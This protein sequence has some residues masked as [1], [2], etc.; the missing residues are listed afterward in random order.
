MISGDLEVDGSVAFDGF[1][2][3]GGNAT[4][5]GGLT[6]T[7]L[8]T[9]DATNDVCR[10]SANRIINCSSSI[11]YKENIGDLKV[12]KEALLSL[13]PV[14]FTWKGS[15]TPDVG[16]IAEEVREQIPELTFDYHGIL[17][18]VKYKQLSVYMLDL[19]KEHE[20][21]LNTIEGLTVE[22]TASPAEV[23]ASE[24]VV[25]DN[26]PTLTAR[27]GSA[28]E[29]LTTLRVGMAAFAS[30]AAE[31]AERLDTIT[32]QSA[33]LASV[34]FNLTD[35][36]IALE[37]RASSGLTFDNIA[38]F[39]GGLRV[40]EIGSV[41]SIVTLLS[42]VNFIG[43]PYFNADTGGFA[44]I[45]SGSQEVRVTFD[46]EYLDTPVINATSQQLLGDD[47]DYGIASAS[48]IDFTIM[49]NKPA[50]KKVTF[51]WIALAVKNPKIFH[52]NTQAPNIKSHPQ[53]TPTPE[54]SIIVSPASPSLG[55]PSFEP[56]PVA[57]PSESP[58][59][60]ETS[61][62][63]P[64]SPDASQDGPE[65][66]PTQTPESTP[67]S[68]SE[69]IPEPTPEAT[70]EPTPE[71]TETPTPGPTPEIV[72]DPPPVEIPVE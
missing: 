56:S 29:E 33:N 69:P 10:S 13:R 40:D 20:I 24:S 18:G 42:D 26:L 59:P 71:I 11:R 36:V 34:S 9:P 35:R 72:S 67:A 25:F 12:N 58:V 50:P 55:G 39:N 48:T 53:T 32:Q 23:R 60:S 65:L 61:T 4:I 3:F 43:R 68:S 51:S 62:A 7:D 22:P 52:S 21:R 45:A 8:G 2:L 47:I 70:P 17:E 31:F 44:Q 57:S 1:A 15:G 6:V 54:P 49:L 63:T 16:L 38:V 64:A 41:G 37:Q 14:S 66:T 5:S 30:S 46:R 28:Q 27:I 19:A